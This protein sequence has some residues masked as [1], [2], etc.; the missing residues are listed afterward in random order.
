[1]KGPKGEEIFVAGR[2][3]CN[4]PLLTKHT[5]YRKGGWLFPYFALALFGSFSVILIGKRKTA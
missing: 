3:L 1:V 5:L 4:L 2:A